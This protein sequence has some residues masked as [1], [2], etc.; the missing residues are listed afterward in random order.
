MSFKTIP[1]VVSGLILLSWLARPASICCVDVSDVPL[2]V[3][4]GVA[5]VLE[6]SLPLG[7]L[8][9]WTDARVVGAQLPLHGVES[10]GHGV[11]RVNHKLHLPLL[12][13]LG[14]DPDALLAWERR[15]GG[16]TAKHTINYLIL[17][18]FSP[19][20]HP[21]LRIYSPVCCLLPDSFV[22][23]LQELHLKL[24]CG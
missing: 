21:Q 7:R 14:V 10:V 4:A 6:Q 1:K 8:H 13:V 20:Y 19:A 15:G 16:F 23:T 18:P 17:H 2:T 9:V 24:Q 5:Y 3:E 12:L 22:L 11:H